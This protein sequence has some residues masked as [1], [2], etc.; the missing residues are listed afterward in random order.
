MDSQMMADACGIDGILADILI[1]RG[2]ASIDQA[3][4]FLSDTKFIFHDPMTM[5]DM[6]KAVARIWRAVEQGEKILIVGDSDADGITATAVLYQYLRSIGAEVSYHTPAADQI[7]AFWHGEFPNITKDIGLIVTVDCGISALSDG[8]GNWQTDVIVTDHHECR[9]TLPQVYAVLDPKREGE[10][11]PY[12]HL[13]GAGVAL[14]LICAMATE[15]GNPTE[16]LYRY[17]DLVAI[18]TVADAMPLTEE[19]RSL[20]KL[21][22]RQMQQKRRLGLDILL[23]S[24]GYNFNRTITASCAGFVIAPRLNAAGRV[25]HSELAIE[26]LCADN[27]VQARQ[28]AEQLA[29]FNRERQQIE[30]VSVETAAAMAEQELDCGNQRLLFLCVRDWPNGIAGI[31]ASRLVDR[32]AL[33]CVVVS[34]N[35]GLGRG[36]ARSVK[37]FNMFSA[38]GACA[39]HLQEFGGHELAAGFTVK[40]ENIEALREAMKRQAELA[41]TDAGCTPGLSVSAVLDAEKI[42]LDLAHQLQKLEPYG[43][44]NPQPLFVTKE[45]LLQELMPLANVR[46]LRLALEKNGRQFTG[47]M[48]GHTLR[49]LRCSTGDMVDIVYALDVN[50]GGNA[51][52]L[53]LIIKKI[54]VSQCCLVE[55][56]E[57]E[58][59]QFMAGTIDRLPEAAIPDRKDVIDV[60]SY[61]LRTM[62]EADVDTPR[63]PMVMARRISRVFGKPFHYSQ[64][65]LSLAVLSELK[66][67]ELYPSGRQ[68]RIIV[69]CCNEKKNL[70]QSALWKRLKG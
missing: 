40:E 53:Q 29:Q 69:K 11:Y 21:G 28:Y 62:G 37:G 7:V 14:K 6:S 12:P 48:F 39:E 16:E 60:Y 57:K 24:A 70:T 43:M 22:L 26:L 52:Q 8:G 31:V 27:A 34:V 13:S 35:N 66:M 47:L 19:N 2:I 45:V 4:D 63:Y 59:E 50:T 65:M 64:L 15:R 30:S 9:Q 61:L 5:R 49:E 46:H 58:Y 36:S 51:E 17:C 10:T 3:N 55:G 38:V 1:E 32:Y 67:V 54:E 20:V 41:Y 18:G 68:I 44:E 42:T 23:R 25:D 33:P 56:Y